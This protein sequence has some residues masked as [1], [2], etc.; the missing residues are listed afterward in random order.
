M[1]Q[2]KKK[3]RAS[4]AVQRAADARIDESLGRRSTR[5]IPVAGSLSES[6]QDEGL[7]QHEQRIVKL[8]QTVDHDHAQRIAGLEHHLVN[9]PITD[10]PVGQLSRI[11]KL[12]ERAEGQATELRRLRGELVRL[13]VRLGPDLRAQ[14]VRFAREKYNERTGEFEPFVI[15]RTIMPDE[16][17]GE[18]AA[19]LHRG[20]EQPYR[21]EAVRR[22]GMVHVSVV[23]RVLE[24]YLPKEERETIMNDLRKG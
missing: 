24:T 6:E 16:I 5:K 8:E 20:S 9:K 21:F 18:E 19:E 13:A 10:G 15:H 2:R 14:G 7:R 12:E 17:T 4:K 1:A 11:L 3:R 23:A 22:D